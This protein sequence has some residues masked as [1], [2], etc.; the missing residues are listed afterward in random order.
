MI[1]TTVGTQLSFDRLIT[2]L[3]E[4]AEFNKD[5]K[6]IAQIGPSEHIYAN[7]DCVKFVPPD[8]SNRYFEEARLIVAHAGMGSVL[9]ALKFHKPIIIF[10]RLASLGE[11]RNEHQLATARWLENK[12]SI[13]VAWNELELK[14]LLDRSSSLLFGE[15]VSDYANPDLIENLTNF[16]NR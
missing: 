13:F 16:I 5:E 4:W 1:F 3:N 8:L 11:H 7:L 15:S 14:E 2:V 10:P 9:T 12:A 6:I